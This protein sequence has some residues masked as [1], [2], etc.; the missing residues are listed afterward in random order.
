[1]NS[2]LITIHLMRWL[3][4]LNTDIIVPNYYLGRWECDVLRVTKAG[5]LYEYEIKTSKADFRKDAKKE[6]QGYTTGIKV[7]KHD[8]IINSKRVSQFYYVVPEGLLKPEEIQPEFGLIY[9]RDYDGFITFTIVKLSKRF[10]VQKSNIEFY[11]HLATNLC[12]KLINAKRK[13]HGH[14]K[15]KV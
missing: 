8:L 11:R 7:N 9:A 13:L 2:N 15:R 3:G 14:D 4:S 1:M 5:M 10:K 12:F 6:Y